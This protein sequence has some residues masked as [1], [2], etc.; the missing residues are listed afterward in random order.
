[1]NSEERLMGGRAE[2][3]VGYRRLYKK[4]EGISG[5]RSRAMLGSE[6]V[7]AVESAVRS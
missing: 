1:M 3:S 6:L 4:S 7:G 5:V 2:Q